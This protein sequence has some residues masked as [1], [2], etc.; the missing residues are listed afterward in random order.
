MKKIVLVIMLVLLPVVSFAEESKT[1]SSDKIIETETLTEQYSEKDVQFQEVYITNKTKQKS[2]LF[3][4]YHFNFF[5]SSEIDIE[6]MDEIKEI[7]LNSSI[8]NSLSF[9]VDFEEGRLSINPAYI[10]NNDDEILFSLKL[11]FECMAPI[12]IHKKVRPYIGLAISTNHLNIKYLG[13]EDNAFGYEIG[14]GILYDISKNIFV[15]LGV[16]YST[17]EFEIQHISAEFSDFTFN[18][19]FGFRF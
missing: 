6:Y 10:D 15:N 7:Q 13:I 5:S 8:Q 12:E 9:G 14:A 16:S 1:E 19:G 4:E 17:V 3:M 11:K 18:T 2:K